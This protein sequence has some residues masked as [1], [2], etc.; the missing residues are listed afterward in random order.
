MAASWRRHGKVMRCDGVFMYKLS[1]FLLFLEEKMYIESLTLYNIR[2]FVKS[3]LEF[4]KSINLLVG[5]NNSGKSTIIKSLYR[6]QNPSNFNLTD[7]RK[8]NLIGR[9]LIDINDISES[10]RSLFNYN[11]K[12]DR[13]EFP[14][15][16]KIKIIF[17]LHNSADDR[18]RKIEAHYFDRT[19]H[20]EF[21]EHEKIE[22]STEIWDSKPLYEFDGLP[23]LQSQ[24]NFIYPFLAKRKASH[25]NNN[26]FGEKESF[27]VGDD[28]RNIAAKISNLVNPTYP[29]HDDFER[30]TKEILGFQVGV[31]PHGERDFNCGIFAE[32]RTMIPIES[33]G[34]GVVNI[35][36]VIVMLLTENRKLYLIEE[37]ENDIH[38]KALKKLLDL[39]VEKSKANQFVI[40][41]H[42]NIVVKHLGIKSTKIFG[43]QWKAYYKNTK[44]NIPT[45]SI[46]EIENTPMQRMRLLE[47]LGYDPWDFD[48]YNS[49]LI[50]E[51]SS[52][53]SLVR[54]FL[55]PE[56]VPKLIDKIK[57]IA[58]SGV[59]DIEARL[60]DF[61]R[62]FVFIHQTPIYHAKAWILADGDK[63]GKNVIKN[64]K[65]KF[66]SWPSDHFV[67][68]QKQNI[69]EYYPKRFQKDVTDINQSKSDKREKKIELIK[70]VMRWVKEHPKEA[71]KEFSDSAREIIQILEKINKTIQAKG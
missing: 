45:T 47:D 63:A 44:D 30:L 54:D 55:I 42:S 65:I 62:L 22:F 4:S 24:N 9:T 20:Y 46:E 31:V 48:L 41:T 37:L 70:K 18:K 67:N 6:L 27:Y 38:P 58:A 14:K 49:Y 26:T 59:N 3:K 33:M 35:L 8:T 19:L 32:D 17:S 66:A 10:E 29:N 60:S 57:T 61:M 25:Y 28:L 21:S 11:L 40:S 69:E 7:I 52:A 16:E 64:L 36:G 23:N 12:D 56:F 13:K 2:S 34:E 5:N 51:E 71:K 50:F 15:T 53:E 39:I 68:L 1:L 43:L